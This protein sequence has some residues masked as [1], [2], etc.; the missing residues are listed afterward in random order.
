[1]LSQ[2]E[3]A[4]PASPKRVV[5]TMPLV[6]VNVVTYNHEKFVARAI[7]SVLEQKTNFEYRLII[8]DDCST[9]NTQ[10]IIR[11][12][13]QQYPERIQVLLA[14]EHRGIEHKDRVGIELLRLNTAKYVALLD[15]DDYWSDPYK[16]QKQVDFLDAHFD[17][18]ICYHNVVRFHD[19]GSLPIS[20]MCPPGQK[21]IST[22]EDLLVSN[23]IPTCSAMFRRG[24]YGELPDWFYTTKAGDWALHVLNAEYGKIGYINEVM[25]AYRIQPAGMWS[26]L[27]P[28]QQVAHLI[29][30]FRL[31]DAHLK[32]KYHRVCSER[33]RELRRYLGYISLGKFHTRARS[34]RL[35]E[36]A[37]W[38]ISAIKYNPCRFTDP[39]QFAYVL[40]SCFIW[41]VRRS[42][43]APS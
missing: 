33:V 1:M 14:S 3:L 19:D 35:L 7:E 12:Y 23:F 36:A 4:D 13:A 27:A 24:L 9:D 41:A 18:A 16:L 21:D 8:G 39:R 30:S 10:S 37:P 29:K 43:G 25:A 28:E 22:I 2:K 15:G 40:K 17:F 5:T 6:D 26:S 31:I 42:R 20:N 11:D 38:L 32:F 34:G